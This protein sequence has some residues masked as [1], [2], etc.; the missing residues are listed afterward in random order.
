MKTLL[1]T[2]HDFKKSFITPPLALKVLILTQKTQAQDSKYH[3]QLS[4]VI[5]KDSD[6]FCTGGRRCPAK[7]VEKSLL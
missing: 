5:Q 7:F 1:H 6:I 3:S 2:K 4:A